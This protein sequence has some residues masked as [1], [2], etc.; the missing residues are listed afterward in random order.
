M[1]NAIVA[2]G[3]RR[4]FGPNKALDGFDLTVREGTVHGLLGPNGSGKT[5]TVRV[6]ST[7]L[8]PDAGRATVAGLDVLTKA[9]EL[10]RII[11]L[12]G[13][14]AAVDE[15]LT[16]RENLRMV[17]RLYHLG[18]TASRQRADELLERFGLTK[19]ADRPVKGYSGGMRRRVDLACAVVSKPQVLFLDE[20]TT[21]LDVR[22][23]MAMWD[24]IAELVRGGSTLLLTTQYLEEADQLADR[25]TVMDQ[26]KVIAE[27][28]P[29][30]LKDRVGGERL[31]ITVGSASDAEEARTLLREIAQ[32]GETSVDEENNRVIVPVSDGPEALVNS[33]RLLDRSQVRL[34]GTTLRRPSMDEVFLAL[35]ERPPAGQQ[36]TG[37]AKE[38]VK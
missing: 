13:Q 10:R 3:L 18:A 25:I 27:G 26:G 24:V 33:V 38:E 14:Y 20:P 6:L 4:S 15:D 19:D 1:T 28:T 11:G 8:R 34:V 32:G 7:L 29:D 21:G 17:A 31:E 16:A 36:A 22:S 9:A 12:S 30:E 35:T 37:R 2:E 5:T 23:R